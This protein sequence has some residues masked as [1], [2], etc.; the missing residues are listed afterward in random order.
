MSGGT[1]C[2][3]THATDARGIIAAFGRP[4]RFLH[5]ALARLSPH[6]LVEVFHREGVATKAEPTGKIFPASDRALDVLGDSAGASEAERRGAGLRGAGPGNRRSR[7]RRLPP[8]H[9]APLGP[10]RHSFGHHRRPFLS[11]LRHQ[12]RRLFLGR[13]LGPRDR[14]SAAGPGP[15][16]ERRRLGHVA[17][18]THRARRA[19]PHRAPGRPGRKRRGVSC[20]N[21]PCGASH[22]R[23]RSLFPPGPVPR[24]VPV[25]PLWTLRSGRAERQ[26]GGQRASASRDARRGLRFP[27]CD[28]GTRAGGPLGPAVCR[29][30]EAAI[31][32]RRALL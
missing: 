11:P 16:A 7:Q 15:L 2:N 22:E 14:A 10:R 13:G 32:E 6:D 31:S 26:P 8:A 4:G 23:R 30:R 18:R 28:L 20:R 25:H 3:L 9:S 17:Y 27:A 24:L 12:R 29:G 5:S 1:R 21:G 19:G